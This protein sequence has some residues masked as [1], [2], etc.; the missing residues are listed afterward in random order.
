MFYRFHQISF[1]SI[2]SGKTFCKIKL[3]SGKIE[4]SSQK[5]KIYFQKKIFLPQFVKFNHINEIFA[6]AH[7]TMTSMNA[8][9]NIH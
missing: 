6:P 5:Y 3:I 1:V 8:K 9:F 4:I 7:E 2:I